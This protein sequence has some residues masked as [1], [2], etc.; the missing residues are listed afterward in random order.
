MHDQSLGQEII[1][2]FPGAPPRARAFWAAPPDPTTARLTHKDLLHPQIKQNTYIFEQHKETLECTEKKTITL[3]APH[4]AAA[5][6]S[7]RRPAPAGQPQRASMVAGGGAEIFHA[8][9]KATA[10]NE[11]VGA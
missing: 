3:P 2:E 5:A 7:P 11:V 4:P 1:G 9:R 10:A 6:P 8:Q